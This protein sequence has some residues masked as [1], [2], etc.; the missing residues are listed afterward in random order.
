MNSSEVYKYALSTYTD[1]IKMADRE[2]VE[3]SVSNI[4]DVFRFCFYK[5]G[6]CLGTHLSG[7]SDSE[8]IEI[9]TP[10]FKSWITSNFNDYFEDDDFYSVDDLFGLNDI[11]DFQNVYDMANDYYREKRKYPVLSIR[12]SNHELP[13][14]H[15]DNHYR[16]F[17]DYVDVYSV[18][19]VS[20]LKNT[21]MKGS[22]TWFEVIKDIYYSFGLGKDIFYELAERCVSYVSSG[23]YTNELSSSPEGIREY[24]YETG[25]SFVFD[26][27]SFSDSAYSVGNAVDMSLEGTGVTLESYS[28]IDSVI[29]LGS[30]SISD[31]VSKFYNSFLKSF[32]A[33]EGD[34]KRLYDWW[35]DTF[36][37]LKSYGNNSIYGRNLYLAVIAFARFVS[38]MESGSVT[39][40][41]FNYD[42]SLF[43]AIHSVLYLFFDE[44]TDY[45][46][47]TSDF[48]TEWRDY[49]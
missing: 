12:V 10:D 2:L 18:S 5:L 17:A 26:D 37:S 7:M 21:Y 15:K 6:L 16:V 27:S 11:T 20:M 8:Y 47:I 34:P 30:S 44:N 19:D 13:S 33:T 39:R 32:I 4:S 40:I 23:K 43:Y 29:E 28:D 48:V 1:V 38:D 35:K 41:P 24:L 42:T 46:N 45:D 25:D 36:S 49:V 3:L 22:L 9:A 31:P 14:S